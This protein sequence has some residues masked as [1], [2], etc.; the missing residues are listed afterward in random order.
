MRELAED[1]GLDLDARD[2]VPG[3]GK[4]D[5]ASQSCDAAGKVVGEGQ[6]KKPRVKRKDKRDSQAGISRVH[7]SAVDP[8]P[9]YVSRFKGPIG[10]HILGK[11]WRRRFLRRVIGW[12][13]YWKR[14][15]CATLPEDKERYEKKRSRTK[16]LLTIAY[17]RGYNGEDTTTRVKIA[18]TVCK[19]RHL[20]NPLGC[21]STWCRERC[22]AVLPYAL[23]SLEQPARNTEGD[24][25]IS[26]AVL[27]AYIDSIMWLHPG[28]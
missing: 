24:I 22:I 28:D 18:G 25:G 10:C 6:D 9:T 4:Y 7:A 20:M 12:V 1:G 23:T 2:G 3:T 17:G 15:S 26:Q 5:S 13:V 27:C 16:P 14:F 21:S 11:A 8:T 19:K